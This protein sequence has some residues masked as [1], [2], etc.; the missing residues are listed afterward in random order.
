MLFRN[1]IFVLH[2]QRLRLLTVVADSN[3]A[4]VIALDDAHAWPRALPWSDIAQLNAERTSIVS[5]KKLAAAISAECDA[6]MARLAPLVARVPDIFDKRIRSRQVRQRAGELGCSPSTLYK[7]LRRYWQRGQCREALMPDFAKCGRRGKGITAKRGPNKSTDYAIYQLT[8]EDLA[9]FKRVLKKKYLKDKRSSIA[10]T[11]QAVLEERYT[12]LDGNGD[13]QIRPLGSRPTERQFRHF[14]RQM[15]STEAVIRGREGDKE[16]EQNHAPKLGTVLADCLGVG[17][18]YEIDATIADLWLVLEQTRSRIIGKATLYLIVDRASNLIV[19]FYVGLEYPS[20]AGAR[21]AI[22]S[23]AQDKAELC[24]MYGVKYDPADWP[25]HQVFPKQF[26]ADRGEMLSKASD[27]VSDD[28]QIGVANLPA[29][30]PQKKP[31]VECNFKLVHAVIKD[32]A[33]AYQ[34]P[35]EA[36]KRR[37]KHYEQDA[38]LTIKEFTTTILEAIIA[39]NRL[40]MKK[41]NLGLK[42][43]AAGVRPTPIA[44]WNDGIVRRS[45]LLTRFTEEHVRQ[46]LL[47][48][49][50]ASVTG[51]GIVFRGCYYTCPEALAAGWFVR[52]RKGVFE[53]TVA[54][55]SRLVDTIYVHDPS[56]S[57]KVYLGTLT[58]R[59]DKYRGLSF[60]EVSVFETM[61]SKMTPDIAQARAQTML[62][63]HTRLN[64]VFEGA[65][66]ELAA[67]GPARSRS[68]RRADTRPDRELERRKERQAFGGAR[69]AATITTPPAPVVALSRS[70]H[71]RTN[72]VDAA[73]PT[74]QA[75]PKTTA[76]LL[77]DARMRMIHG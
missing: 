75:G 53:V 69:P 47:T 11:F 2:S 67:Q 8:T 4:W 32:V 41:F 73:N 25:A 61:L 76:Q 65:K 36:M 68:A 51:E 62:D 48:K 39:R 14:L 18:Y 44:L 43:I 59:S 56:G 42:Q 20:W 23:I 45:G 50:P 29:D 27:Y 24:R 66:R 21:Q 7:H 15:C 1:D 30:S 37:G 35:D 12:F 16:F 64:P 77:R 58:P 19:G 52:G 28:L 34:P 13:P 46:A 74:T 60:A 70:K 57:G 17:H 33:P 38:C 5:G 10:A 3:A 71:K 40:E 54:Y 31:L 9:H 6:A 49:E 26:L 55:D 72:D 63:L 22:L